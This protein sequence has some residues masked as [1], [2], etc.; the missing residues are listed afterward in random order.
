MKFG[1]TIIYV[2]DVAATLSFFE[3]AFGFRM[4]FVHE[5]DYGELDTGNTTLA[6]ASHSLASSNFPTSYIAVDSSPVPLGIEIAFVTDSILDAHQQ[7]VKAGARS[8][9]DPTEKPWGQ[10]VSYLQCPDG[11]LIELCSPLPI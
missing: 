5:N 8:L 6:F 11:I 1:Y 3:K 2:K 7:A 10:V 9:K 4:R